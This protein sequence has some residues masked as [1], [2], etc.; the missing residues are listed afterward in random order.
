ML[1]R[2]YNFLL[3]TANI[4]FIVGFILLLS[5]V[6]KDVHGFLHEPRG[7]LLGANGRNLVEVRKVTKLAGSKCDFDWREERAKHYAGSDEEWKLQLERNQNP[8]LDKAWAHTLHVPERGC[9]LVHNL[10]HTFTEADDQYLNGVVVFLWDHGPEGS[11]GLVLNRPIY[12]KLGEANAVVPDSPL[13][14]CPIYAGGPDG[15]QGMLTTMHRF[16]EMPGTKEIVP[17]ICLGAYIQDIEDYVRKGKATPD[18]FRFFLQQKEWGPGELERECN[19]LEN[20]RAVPVWWPSAMSKE[21]TLKHCIQLPVPLWRE[22]CRLL[23]GKFAMIA[24][25]VYDDL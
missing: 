6:D 25:G 18:D 17:G 22:A 12:Y 7:M 21:F 16:K 5:V 3:S 19:P 11:K 14:D 8:A 10:K 15:T 13:C 2:G 1:R 20:P 9:T 4:R 23:G 24:R